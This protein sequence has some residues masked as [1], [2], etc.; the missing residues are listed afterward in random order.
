MFTSPTKLFQSITPAVSTGAYQISRSLRF[1]SADTAYLSRTPASAGNL[2]TWTWSSWIKRSN[3]GADCTFFNNFRSSPNTNEYVQLAFTSSDKLDLYCRDASAVVI[4]RLVTTQV[5]RDVGAWYHIVCVANTTNATSSSRLQ[6][7]VNGIQI[8]AFDTATYP[9]Q[10]ANLGW[11]LARAALIGVADSSTPAANIAAYQTEI[12]F[13]DGQALT[14]SSFG[15]TDSATGV[16]NPIAYTGT[17]GTNGFYLNFSDNSN[18]TAATLGKDYSPNGNNFTPNNFSVTAGAGNDSLVDTPTNYGTDT[19]VGGEVRGNYST[20][21]PTATQGTVTLTNGNLDI[22]N[23]ANSLCNGTTMV[24]SGKW[25]WEVKIISGT[26]GFVGAQRVNIQNIPANKFQVAGAMFYYQGNGNKYMNGDGGSAY[27]ASYTTNDVIGVALNLDANTITFYKNN[28]SQGAITIVA[29]DWVPCSVTGGGASSYE[30]NFGQRAFAYT[31]PSGFEALVSTNL[32]TPTVGASSTTLASAYMLPVIYTGNSSTQ[33]ITTGF[34]PD[35]VWI[36]SRSTA[37]VHTLQDVLRG[38]KYYLQSNSTAAEATQADS[39]GISAFTSTGFTLG[40]TDSDAWNK[41]PNTYVSWNWKAGGAG[42]S[43]T[44]GSITSN[45]SV[46]TTAGFSV[47]TYTSQISG[48]ATIGH[49]LGVAPAM[50]LVKPLTG[51][52]GWTVYH[53]SIGNAAYLVL[54]TTAASVTGATTVWDSTSPTSTVFTQGTAFTNLG[55]MVAYCFAEVA[56]FSKFGSYVGN[57]SADGPFAYCGFR[58]RFIMVKN[59]SASAS[60]MMYDTSRATYN[61]VSNP[62]AAD[63]SLAELNSTDWYIDIL[64]NGFKLRTTYGQ[65]NNNTNTFI[66]MAFAEAP[67]NYS[68]AR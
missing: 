59:A 3:L 19:G 47:V 66:F 42:V 41:S 46:S 53:I 4:G 48:S 38:S 26:D 28:T 2:Q 24:T 62:L 55:T 45:V 30:Y 20:L 5:F 23:G 31:A 15:Q 61:V 1:N 56:G 8:T 11:N 9:S 16:W 39:D 13:I 65:V 67:F 64:S 54:N 58:P 43:N 21:N 51:T 22:A 34:Q 52:V 63:L 18:T 17:Y 57:G 44:N 68:R 40:Y 37:D 32:P 50:I 29:G 27:G 35:F 12:N 49:G 36:K 6:L 33:N 25:Y 14:P 60:W 7:Y 10:N